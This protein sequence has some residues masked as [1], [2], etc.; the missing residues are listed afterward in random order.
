MLCPPDI[1]TQPVSGNV[2]T[3]SNHN[4]VIYKKYLRDQQAP[5]FHHLPDGTAINFQV[6]MNLRSLLN[7]FALGTDTH[8]QEEIRWIAEEM[9]GLTFNTMPNLK[10]HLEMLVNQK[11]D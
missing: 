8:A 5:I 1:N 3:Q 2:N 10:H 11:Q 9:M 4:A 6:T 7:F